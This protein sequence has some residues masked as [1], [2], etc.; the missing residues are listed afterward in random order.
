M[1]YPECIEVIT[2]LFKSLA[3]PFKMI[4]LHFLPVISWKT[5]VLS[6]HGKSSAAPLLEFQVI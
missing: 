1:V 6:L 3:P 2:H 5:P 4:F